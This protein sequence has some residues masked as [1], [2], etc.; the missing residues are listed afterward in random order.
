MPLA[1]AT[2]AQPPAR[3]PST[4]AHMMLAGAQS[5]RAVAL[6]R[7]R[8]LEMWGG[9]QGQDLPGTTQLCLHLA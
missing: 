6:Q 2:L 3:S 1:E 4:R 9:C 8:P 5:T 7:S